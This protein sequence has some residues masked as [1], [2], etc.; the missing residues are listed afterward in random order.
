MSSLR[1]S[2]PPRRLRQTRLDNLALV[3]GDLLLHRDAWQRAA[4]RLPGKAILI[5]LPKANTVQKRIMLT[6]AKL[7]AAQGHQVRVVPADAVSRNP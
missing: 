1:L 5:V 2:H 3:P 7:L 4:N 6:V